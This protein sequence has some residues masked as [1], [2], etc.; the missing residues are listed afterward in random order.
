MHWSITDWK[1]TREEKL[2]FIFICKA[3]IYEEILF[4]KNNTDRSYGGK[5][6]EWPVQGHLTGNRQ[7]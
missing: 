6:A 7:S 5:V 3:R 4:E 1:E 2:S